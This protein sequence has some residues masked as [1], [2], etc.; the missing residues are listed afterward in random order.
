MIDNVNA[1]DIKRERELNEALELLHFCFRAVI[2]EPD[3]ILM[4]QGFGRAHHRIL[5]FLAHQPGMLMTEL[6]D[7]L[8]VSRQALHRPLG[9]LLRK[10]HLSIEPSQHN[11]RNNVLTLTAKGMALERTISGLQRDAFQDAFVAAGP[12]A[13]RHWRAIMAHIAATGDARSLPSKRRPLKA[14]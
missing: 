6:I 8:G 5:Y 12:A 10:G 14:D 7:V 3:R 4:K 1:I 9:D 2:A 11:R 13:E